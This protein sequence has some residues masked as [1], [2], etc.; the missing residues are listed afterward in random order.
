MEKARLGIVGLGWFGDVLA[1]GA[2]DSGLAEVMSCY[3]RSEDAREA[4]AR[5]H[6]CRAASSL[7][8]LLADVDGVVLATPHSTHADQIERAAAEGTH[9]FVEKP[10]TLTAEDARRAIDATQRA[11]VTLQ[12][13]FNRRR[14][15]AVRRIKAMIDDGELGTLL[16]IEGFHSAA[17]G[18]RPDLPAWRSDPAECPAGGMTPLGVHTIDTFHYWAGPAVRVAAFSSQIG[19][20]STLDQATT[21]IVE[22]EGG[23]LG[24]INTSYFTAP[25]VT[26]AAYG[27]DTSAWSE[28]DGARLFLQARSEKARTERDVAMLDTI[29][30]EMGEFARCILHAERP[31]TGGAEG[32]E[33][34]AVLEAALR[35]I[36]TGRVVDL[37]DIR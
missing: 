3:A 26:L 15:P 14:H 13:G 5:D 7:E 20:L 23:V 28:E 35:S 22:Y 31:E 30:D 18:F 9:V 17:G 8:E 10:L 4:F 19:G 32:L 2:V 11:G 24:S 34:V 1:R 29:Q 25:V 37:S 12:V 36:E 6:G 27:T 33:A 16:Q 21:V